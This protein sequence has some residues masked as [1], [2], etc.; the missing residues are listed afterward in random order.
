MNSLFLSDHFRLRRIAHSL[1]IF[2]YRLRPVGLAGKNGAVYMLGSNLEM[3][4]TSQGL[5]P[6]SLTE[7][8]SLLTSTPIQPSPS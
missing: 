8:Y 5:V 7:F 3:R 4:E 6:H 1:G 2:A